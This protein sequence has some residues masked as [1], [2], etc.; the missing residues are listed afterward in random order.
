MLDKATVN[1]GSLFAQK[2]A[3]RVSTEARLQARSDCIQCLPLLQ[4]VIKLTSGK[5]KLCYYALLEVQGCM[6][7]RSIHAWHMTQRWWLNE[8]DGSWLH[9]AT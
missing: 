9:T 4:G 7:L 5:S 2:V 8:Q 1:I 3:G 6:W